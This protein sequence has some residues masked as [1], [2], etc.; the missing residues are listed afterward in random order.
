MKYKLL[1]ITILYSLLLTSCSKEDEVE[2]VL[3]NSP[4]ELS[5]RVKS[6]TH[7]GASFRATNVGSN[8]EQAVNNLYLFLFDE[9]GNN[10]LKYNIG[11]ATTDGTFTGGSFI[12]SDK[13]II[14][15][16]TRGEAGVRNVYLV[17][18]INA[19]LRS[20]LGGVTTVAGL[21]AVFRNT[22]SPWSD[23][24]ATP[25]LMSGNATHNFIADGHKLEGV[26]LTRAVAKIELNIKLTSGF[27]VV[28]TINSGNLAE[29]KFRYVD[30]DSRTYVEKPLP[31]KPDNLVSSS[32]DA[33]PNSSNWT[34]WGASL[35]GA[36][37]LDTGLGYTINDSG[38]VTNLKLITYLNERD[39]KGSKVEIELP[40]VD[41]GPLPPPEFG[42][43]LYSLPLPEKIERN[44]WYVYDIEI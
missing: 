37:L 19:D 44:N 4:I 40:R 43:E 36:D 34:P 31:T 28:P 1:F 2:L 25:L 13:K 38:K 42:P 20:L 29:Y 22:T 21:Q 33:W 10:P 6:F 12:L 3:N 16:M 24:I 18:N 9:D 14:L 5:F 32:A 26:V 15:D 17:A 27:Q 23:N 41:E 39:M 7:D 30:F 11:D 35:N 8:A